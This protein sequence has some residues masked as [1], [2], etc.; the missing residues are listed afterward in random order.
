MAVHPKDLRGSGK[1][2]TFLD[3][4][5]LAE[6]KMQNLLTS[7]VKKAKKRVSSLSSHQ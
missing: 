3:V 5:L 1:G 2:V 6:K 7:I 4:L